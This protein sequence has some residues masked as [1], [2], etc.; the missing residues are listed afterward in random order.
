MNSW[1]ENPINMNMKK[2]HT[3]SCEGIQMKVTRF[4]MVITL[5]VVVVSRL[6]SIVMQT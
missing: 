3:D 2:V 1:F 5:A 4:K 6:T